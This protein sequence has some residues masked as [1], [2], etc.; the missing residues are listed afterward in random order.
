MLRKFL[1]SLIAS[2]WVLSSCSTVDEF[3]SDPYK[4]YDQLWETLDKNYCYFDLKLPRG[5]TW[6]DLYHKHRVHLRPNMSSDSLFL[7]MTQLLSELKDGHVNLATP[8]DYGRYWRWK[9]DFPRGYDTELIEDYLGDDY[10]IAGAMLYTRLQ[11]NGHLADSIGYIRLSS[12]ASGLSD[13]NINAA[14]SRLVDCRALILDIRGNGGGQVTT[15]DLLARH[16][17]NKGRLIGYMS[18]KTGPGHNDF[19]PKHPL[20]LKPLERGLKW[21][22]PVVLLVDRG[23]YSAANDF[24][25]RMKGLPFVTVMGTQTGGGAGLPMSSELPNGWGVRFSSSRTFDA[26]GADIEFGIQPDKELQFSQEKSRLGYDT[27]IEGAVIYLRDRFEN[28]KWTRRWEK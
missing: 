15:S 4:N 1:Y 2:I 3:S 28:F 14:L 13:G 8:F 9:S 11:K 21:L 27:M 12:F 5:V 22:R 17:I 23:V 10:R 26:S 19:S 24:T 6:R 20:H 7:I 25:L 18:H 16:F